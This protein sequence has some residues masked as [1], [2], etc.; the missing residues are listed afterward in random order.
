MIRFEKIHKRYDDGFAALTDINLN[1]DAGKLHVLIGPSGCGKTTTMKLV[2]RLIRPSEGK[3]FIRD[4]EISRI[5]PVELRRSIG[6]VIQ[7]I[8]LF[9]HMSIAR[10]VGVVPHLLKWNQK[11]IDERTDELLDLVGLDPGTYRERRPHELSGGQQPRVGV[12]RALAADPD[13]LLMDERV[14]A[15]DPIRRGQVQDEF[16]RLQDELNKTIVFVT[17]DMDEAIKIADNIVFMRE[18]GIIQHGRP[19]QILRHPAN[20]F[21]ENFVG[22]KRL[23]NADDQL[24]VED[25]MIDQPVTASPSRGLAE[26]L[27]MME[28]RRVDSLYIVDQKKKAVGQ[29]T[30]FQVLDAYPD[31]NKTL[32]DIMQPIKHYA[33]PSMPLI[34]A[35]QMMNDQHMPNLAIVNEES[36]FIGMITRGSVVRHMIEVYPQLP[37]ENENDD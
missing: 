2:N 5:D 7:N 37:K 21:V 27:K 31:E 14:S 8:G 23:Q 28:R 16:L 17:H 32:A 26:S 3:I 1:F 30:I 20:E 25:V 34:D 15:L 18:G 35:L 9:P 33:E 24:V 12:I 36:K 6:Y 4:Q 29:V 22:K 11:K 10:N 19:E 13:I